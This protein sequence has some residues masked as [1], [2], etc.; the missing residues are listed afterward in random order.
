MLAVVVPDPL[1]PV[2]ALCLSSGSRSGEL[3]AVATSA[4]VLFLAVGERGVFFL[5]L[6]DSA[7]VRRED[8]ELGP[9]EFPVGLHHRRPQRVGVLAV[10]RHHLL[11]PAPQP[12]DRQAD[13]PVAVAVVVA[14]VV[15]AV[16]EVAAR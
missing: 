6:V 10:D 2:A 3:P 14:A 11:R 15:R 1:P 4:S 13:H 12:V 8:P 9:T 5:A 7:V 16:R